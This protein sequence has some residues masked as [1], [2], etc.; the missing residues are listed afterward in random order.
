MLISDAL[1]QTENA[2]NSFSANSVSGTLIQ[3]GLIFVIFYFLLIRPQQK[4]IREHE[5]MLNAIKKGDKIITGGGVFGTVVKAGGETLTVEI[6]NGIE[7][8]VARSSVRDMAQTPDQTPA[9]E[10]K[11]PKKDKKKSAKK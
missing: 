11:T 5:N 9:A 4:K 7:I 10:T 3:L 8:V 2:V 1:A 6:A